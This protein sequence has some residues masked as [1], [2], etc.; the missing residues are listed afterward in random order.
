MKLQSLEFKERLLN[1]GDATLVRKLEKQSSLSHGE[2]L[3]NCALALYR[4]YNATE[5]FDCHVTQTLWQN[6]S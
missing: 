3:N 5:N 1:E 2:E 4:C 6:F